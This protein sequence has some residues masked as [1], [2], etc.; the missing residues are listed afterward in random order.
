MSEDSVTRWIRQLH[1]E[2]AEPARH[3]LA[4]HSAAEKIWGTYES[5]LLSLAARLLSC[6]VRRVCDPDDVVASAFESFFDRA[7]RG[8]IPEDVH[9]DDL[10]R[11]LARIVRFKAASHTR[12]EL[13]LKRGGGRQV[14]LNN[15]DENGDL[16]AEVVGTIPSPA[17]AA[18]VAE[19]IER[20]MELLDPQQQE[21]V[22]LKLEG[23]LDR[24]IS[25]QLAISVPTVERRMRLIRSRWENWLTQQ[26]D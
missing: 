22:R 12:R 7:S 10:W 13:R 23:A 5:R 8:D 21:I 17:M 18:E 2:R 9:R 14:D 1:P 11:L 24:E 3:D 4:R 25:E 19:S 26:D 6:K 16:L 15:G 20:L